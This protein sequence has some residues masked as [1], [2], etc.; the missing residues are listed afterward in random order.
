M[1]A[2]LAH[3]S[4]NALQRLQVCTDMLSDHVSD[5]RAA[6]TLLNRSQQAQADLQR[7]LDE[8]R[9]FAAPMTLDRTECRLPVLWREAW[10]LLHVPRLGRQ[11]ELVDAGCEGLAPIQG[12]RFRLV[13]AF[14]NVFENSMAACPDPVVVVITC[15][16]AM[17]DG[18][19]ATEICIEDNGPGFDGEGSHRAFEPFFTTKSTGTGLGLAIV[20][21]TVEAHGGRVE[22]SA[23]ERGGARITIVLPRG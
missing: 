2:R 18:A 5:N 16:D 19:R 20:R 14:R 1:Y 15:R 7:L 11:A 3:E 9:N 4:R 8:V 10:G 22:A 21:R 12:D 13:Q 6:T 17:L 23:G